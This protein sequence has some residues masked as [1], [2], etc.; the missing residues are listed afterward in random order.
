[1][2]ELEGRRFLITGAVGGIGRA[3]ARCFADRGAR[4]ALLDLHAD[5]TR[6][7][8]DEVGAEAALAADVSREHAVE[9]AVAGAERAL[10]GL[11]GVVNIAGINPK[12]P[13]DELSLAEWSRVLDVNLTGTFLVCRAALPL[14]RRSSGATIVN[15]STAAALVPWG[16]GAA[17]YNA[18]K[19]GVIALTKALALELGPDIRV[20]VVCP[21]AVDTDMFRNAVSGE[22]RERIEQGYALKRIAR[23]DEVARAVVFLSSAQS[24]FTTGATLTVDG[25]RSYW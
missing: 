2:H 4:L 15:M 16:P 10:G 18:S 24:S 19:G 23:T 21:G 13:L 8:A 9:E 25:G 22:A 12:A 20:N 6:S 11:D 14:L 17:A 1:M 5:A 7:V 3:T